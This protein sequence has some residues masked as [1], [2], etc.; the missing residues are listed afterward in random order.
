M[1]NYIIL[2]DEK[3][4]EHGFEFLDLIEYENKEYIVII[5]CNDFG[6]EDDEVLI[7]KIEEGDDG[8]DTYLSVT[9]CFSSTARYTL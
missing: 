1:D 8:T 4:K 2:T 5:P 6:E 7:L 9:G 3:G